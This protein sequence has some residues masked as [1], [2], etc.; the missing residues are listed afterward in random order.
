MTYREARAALAL[1]ALALLVASCGS[2]T[3]AAT[4][5]APGTTAAPATTAAPSTAPSTSAAPTTTEAPPGFTITSDLVYHETDDRFRGEG[6]VDVV[7]PT[8]TGPWPIVVAFH[9]DP[10]SVGKS[11]MMPTAQSIA[12]HGR[13]VFVPD[14]GHINWTWARDA[15]QAEEFAATEA[16]IRCAV[17]FARHR[18]DDFGGDPE[19]ITVYGYSAG[20]NAALM[21]GFGREPA[22]DSCAAGGDPVMPQAIVS[23]D[24][25]VLLG[26]GVW[27]RT[28]KE[29][30]DAFYAMTPWRRLDEPRPLRVHIA[31]VENTFGPYD[32]PLG[33]DPY[34]SPVA[35]RHTDIDLV[36]S[37]QAMGLLDDGAFSNRD[38][39][40][41]A[42]A[43]LLDAGYDVH[44]VLLPDSNHVSLSAEGR[45]LLIDTVV[46]AEG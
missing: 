33:D 46:N 25:D 20:G 6:L 14:W 15:T 2:P 8:G 41:W 19:H 4:S 43:T 3:E 16:Q 11:W 10:N 5:A 17:A 27:D 39:N 40:E 13:V 24:G 23:G 22:L 37:L 34:A 29:E 36:A 42:Y 35:T 31:A 28:F 7:V 45:A 26:A 9:G 32:R 12:E 18:G 38:A 21:A 44:W 1:L 30:P